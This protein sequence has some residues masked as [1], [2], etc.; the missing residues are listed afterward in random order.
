MRGVRHIRFTAETVKIG[1]KADDIDTANV[2][3]IFH[4][5]YHNHRRCRFRR[6]LLLAL[7]RR[8]EIVTG[9]AATLCELTN[10]FIRKVSQMEARAARIG[11]GRNDRTSRMRK[12]VADSGII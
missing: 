9:D 1:S 11:M 5:A 10:H 2:S 6:Q 4:M 8:S 3:Q 7:N 12:N